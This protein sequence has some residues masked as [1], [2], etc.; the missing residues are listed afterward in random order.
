MTVTILKIRA[1]RH[2][3]QEWRHFKERRQ[4]GGS[5]KRPRRRKSTPLTRRRPDQQHRKPADAVYG[6]VGE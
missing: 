6:A 1:S 5:I 2:C 3:W 4:D